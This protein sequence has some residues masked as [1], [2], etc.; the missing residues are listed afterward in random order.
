MNKF[1]RSEILMP[2]FLCD[3]LRSELQSFVFNQLDALILTPAGKSEI[4]NAY[5]NDRGLRVGFDPVSMVP[6][7]C[8][9]IAARL[10]IRRPGG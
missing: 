2:C 8:I 7:V 5:K 10:W 1:R 3:L 9:C 6:P 4:K